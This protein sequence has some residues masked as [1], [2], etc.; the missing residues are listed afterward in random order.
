MPGEE[1]EVYQSRPIPRFQRELALGLVVA[2]SQRI[3]SSS[4]TPIMNKPT[5][6]VGPRAAAGR[7]RKLGRVSRRL[8]GAL[9]G[10]KVHRSEYLSYLE[11]KYR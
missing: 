2:E 7:K 3:G 11:Q 6:K 9:R 8:L 1:H 4:R 5:L 10:L